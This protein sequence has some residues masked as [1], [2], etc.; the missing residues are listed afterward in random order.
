MESTKKIGDISSVL[1]KQFL[2]SAGNR[3]LVSASKFYSLCVIQKMAHF[4]CRLLST[5]NATD[6]KD[7]LLRVRQG[8]FGVG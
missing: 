7:P 2:V 4:W 1:Q 5:N 6:N 8:I 3:S